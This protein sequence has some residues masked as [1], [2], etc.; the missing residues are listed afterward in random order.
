MAWR[1]W[2]M[3]SSPSMYGPPHLLLPSCCDYIVIVFEPGNA[4]P[5]TRLTPPPGPP[6]IMDGSKPKELMS[7]VSKN[8][9]TKGYGN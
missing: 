8:L 5:T 4:R 3:S 1:Q 9:V 2:V 6:A 7:T